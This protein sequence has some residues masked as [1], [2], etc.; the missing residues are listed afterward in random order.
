VT[1][2][3]RKSSAKA[4]PKKGVMQISR[5]DNTA[6]LSIVRCGSPSRIARP[7]NSEPRPLVISIVA[8]RVPIDVPVSPIPFK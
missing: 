5:I 7:A 2:A 8:S 6:P 3:P 4:P 1:P